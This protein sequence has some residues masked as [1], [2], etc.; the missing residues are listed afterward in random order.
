MIPTTKMTTADLDKFFIGL[1]N[2][3]SWENP[4][5][6]NY[7]PYNLRKTGDQSYL[8]EIAVAGFGEDDI[9]IE[10]TEGVLTVKGKLDQE[11]KDPPFVHKGI[12]SR[13]FVRKFR[14]APNVKVDQAEMT[15]G[16]LRIRLFEEVPKEKIPIKIP[17]NTKTNTRT[18]LT[19][20]SS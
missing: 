7:P 20:D 16:I 5:K 9:M 19:E 2:V 6:D 11:E 3:L 8:V 4:L 12:A 13:P 1:D 17:I 18:F 14:M 10:V 15:N